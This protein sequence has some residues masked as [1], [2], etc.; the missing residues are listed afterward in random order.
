MNRQCLEDTSNSHRVLLEAL[1]EAAALRPGV[2]DTSLGMALGL[3][4]DMAT[5]FAA[6]VG[7]AEATG[8][9]FDGAPVADPVAVATSLRGAAVLPTASWRET[10]GASA[11]AWS[12]K[13]TLGAVIGGTALE[14]LVGMSWTEQEHG[15]GRGGNLP[16]KGQ[17]EGEG[18]GVGTSLAAAT[19]ALV[20]VSTSLLRDGSLAGP[21]G[22]SLAGASFDGPASRTTGSL[23][24][25]LATSLA[26]SLTVSWRPPWQRPW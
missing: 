18:D 20:E 9:S 6:E 12:L 3:G 21:A 26:T 22:P 4:L 24:A 1:V 13:A 10:P 19:G 14:A 7:A 5:A 8:A 23:G 11:V 17:N 16:G 15:T 2:A 25:S